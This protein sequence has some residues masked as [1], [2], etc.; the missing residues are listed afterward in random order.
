MA[1]ERG[2][3][4]IVLGIVNGSSIQSQLLREH[5]ARIPPKNALVHASARHDRRQRSGH[6]K[7]S[8]ERINSFGKLASQNSSHQPFSSS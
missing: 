5:C 7:L 1:R 2:N 3:A 8:I 6:A 4:S